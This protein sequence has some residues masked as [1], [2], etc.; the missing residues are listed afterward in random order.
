MLKGNAALFHQRFGEEIGNVSS[1]I[2]LANL[3]DDACSHS[4]SN[5]MIID[6]IVLL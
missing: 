6:S 2:F 5:S 3:E 4:F 1:P